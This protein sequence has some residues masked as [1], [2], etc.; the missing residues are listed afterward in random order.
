MTTIDDIR[1]FLHYYA[2]INDKVVNDEKIQAYYQELKGFDVVVVR[3]GFRIAALNN[4]IG[5]RHIKDIPHYGDVLDACNAQVKTQDN[6]KNDTLTPFQEW[7]DQKYGLFLIF[8]D[9]N[10]KDWDIRSNLVVD[11]RNMLHQGWSGDRYK[12]LE[13]IKWVDKEFYQ[14]ARGEA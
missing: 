14:K 7:V 13:R 4:K 9:K 11:Y 3:E 10:V 12:D 5:T 1:H 2:K 6:S 8:C